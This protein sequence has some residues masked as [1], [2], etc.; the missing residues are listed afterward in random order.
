MTYR[1]IAAMTLL[2]ATF[3]G[4]ACGGNSPSSALPAAI[5][6][7]GPLINSIVGAVPGL[8]QAQAALGA[9]SLLGL[10]KAKMPAEQFST[11]AGAVP[12]VDALVGE[13]VK[14]GAPA[15]PAS[16]SAVADFLAKSGIS[17]QQVGQIAGSLTSSIAG[18]VPAD[19]VTS[20]TNAL[21]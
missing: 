4:S 8:S 12:G 5:S 16:R 7:A 17:P 18:K 6:A 21:L 1:S 10:A 11:L 19:I 3:L 20:L 15:A 14:Q 13:A 9:G 2:A